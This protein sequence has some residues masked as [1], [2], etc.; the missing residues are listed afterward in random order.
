MQKL[1][2]TDSKHP[3][4]V[5]LV[6]HLNSYLKTVDGDDHEF[7][8]QYN[9]IA[10]L[11]NTVVA[12]INDTPVGCGAFK[13]FSDN[14][15]EIK[16]MFTLPEYRGKQI[17]THILTE[18]ETWANELGYKSSILETGKRQIEA[19]NFY[20]KN[21]YKIIKNFGPYKGV[22]NSVCFE[23]ELNYEKG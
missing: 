16:R 13:A 19:V 3:D 10:V 22:D 14:S 8:M 1:I 2:R 17:A 12:Y 20:K 21:K 11:K 7:Y 5:D 4:F 15:V 18:L 6:S 23:K 9:G